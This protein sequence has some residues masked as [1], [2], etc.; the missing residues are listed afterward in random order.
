MA[1]LI[2]KIFYLGVIAVFPLFMTALM[3]FRFLGPLPLL[4]NWWTGATLIWSTFFYAMI[5]PLFYKKYPFFFRCLIW[6]GV[7]SF[8]LGLSAIGYYYGCVPSGEIL[9]CKAF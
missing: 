3:T 1:P 2:R 4:D 8:L 5:S 9:M 7:L 6:V